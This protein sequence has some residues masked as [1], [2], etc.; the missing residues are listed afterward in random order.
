M[1]DHMVALAIGDTVTR[2]LAG[3]I[4]AYTASTLDIPAATPDNIT[5]KLVIDRWTDLPPRIRAQHKGRNLL[6]VIVSKRL[7]ILFI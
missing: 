5:V 7:Q 1:G 4:F 3:E 6:R 2:L